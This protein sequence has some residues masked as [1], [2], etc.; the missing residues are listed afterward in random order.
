[1][2]GLTSSLA[3]AFIGLAF[4][5]AAIDAEEATINLSGVW[6][7][8]WQS[9]RARGFGVH[10]LASCDGGGMACGSL[11]RLVCHRRSTVPAAL[12]RRPPLASP[13]KAWWWSA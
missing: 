2:K 12:A 9:F 7:P 8:L 6:G 10:A 5:L 1:M 3:I 11:W 13:V 4:V